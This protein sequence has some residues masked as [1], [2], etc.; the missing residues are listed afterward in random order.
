MAYLSGWLWRSVY[1]F[2]ALSV[3]GAAVA[4]VSPAGPWQSAHNVRHSLVGQVLSTA[5]GNR[6]TPEALIDDLV[7]ADAVLLGEIHDN[8]DHHALQAWVVEQLIDRGRR[9][10]VIFEM[11]PQDFSRPLAT[12]LETPTHGAAGL[13]PLLKWNQRGWPDWKMYQPI[14]EAALTA[15]LR[16]KAGDLGKDAQRRI[17]REGLDALEPVFRRRLIVDTPLEEVNKAS[18]LDQL[19]EGH[20]GMMPKQALTPMLNVQRSRDAVMADAVLA[21]TVAGGAVLIAGAGHVRND[22]AVPWYVRRRAPGKRVRTVAFVEADPELLDPAD[23]ELTGADGT[24]AFDYIW[25]TP[26]ATLTDHCAELRKR[27]SKMKKHKSE[28]APAKADD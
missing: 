3:A 12:Y 22:W 1:A 8:P 19:H 21:E 26:R 4:G 10:A 20:C 6:S 15:G 28:Q 27:F 16:L 17:G 7:S 14:A 5:T 2:A 23:Y 25:F 18:L 11:I 13:G 9:P 24:P